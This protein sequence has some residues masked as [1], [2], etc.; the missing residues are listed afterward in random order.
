MI[1]YLAVIQIVCIIRRANPTLVCSLKN[2]LCVHYVCTS[3]HTYIPH[4]AYRL[5]SWYNF[6][7]FFNLHIHNPIPRLK[8][9]SLGHALFLCLHASL[10]HDCS[11]K[12]RLALAYSRRERS[13]FRDV[14]VTNKLHKGGRAK[15]RRANCHTT[16]QSANRRTVSPDHAAIGEGLLMLAPQ[17]FAFS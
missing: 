11:M 8:L 12:G 7:K 4:T 14:Q 16:C 6:R 10:M 5:H 15:A 2:C 9:F 13:G 3:V 17:C 1:S